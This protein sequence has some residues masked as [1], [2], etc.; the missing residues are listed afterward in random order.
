MQSRKD[1]NAAARKVVNFDEFRQKRLDLEWRQF[2]WQE[3]LF[4]AFVDMPGR[5]A[6]WVA[7]GLSEAWDQVRGRPRDENPGHYYY[8]AL[9]NDIRG[10]LYFDRNTLESDLAFFLRR[11]PGK[12]FQQKSAAIARQAFD[13]SHN[14]HAL[15]ETGQLRKF[16]I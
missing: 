1:F 15:V 14:F 5:A 13:E 7:R 11:G 9:Q 6:L 10:D 4:S 3:H 2:T 12:K 16:E 8:D